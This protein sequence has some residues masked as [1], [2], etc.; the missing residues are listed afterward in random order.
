MNFAG[1]WAG[2]CWQF[3]L[4]REVSVHLQIMFPR[5]MGMFIA[6]LDSIFN[7]WSQ[8]SQ[9][10]YLLERTLWPEQ[11]AETPLHLNL[12]N[13][14]R[15]LT[16]IL[17]DSFDQ[18]ADGIFNA[19]PALDAF[20]AWFT[21]NYDT[22][23]HSEFYAVLTDSMLLFRSA[24]II[25]RMKRRFGALSPQEPVPDPIAVDA[26]APAT[27]PTAASAAPVATDPNTYKNLFFHTIEKGMCVVD[28]TWRKVYV[29]SGP[30]SK[31]N[32]KFF[33][34][35]DS[36]QQRGNGARSKEIISFFIPRLPARSLGLMIVFMFPTCQ[37]RVVRFYQSCSSP[38]PSSS[39]SASSSSSTTSAT[40]STSTV[41]LP[42]LVQALCQLRSSVRTA[43]P[44]PSQLSARRWT[45]TWDL[46][47]SVRTAGPQPG[48]C[49]AQCA[50]LDLNPSSVR[51]AGSQKPDRMPQ[52]MPDRMSDRMRED[53][54]DKM[55]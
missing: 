15:P 3:N 14:G 51:T 25:L 26:P 54:P 22:E 49:R 2:K 23:L 48:T 36:N 32:D 17:L 18:Y 20:T 44:Q 27:I 55:P 31:K 37:V 16:E 39:S 6:G 45:S 8:T 35:S 7:L 43:G 21:E 5:K 50:P 4:G 10:L 13:E 9:S 19:I 40:T 38:P 30:V 46:P 28:Q 12:P 42:T 53:M 33:F 41:A 29:R 1:F 11:P 24:E 47:S 34:C 52:D